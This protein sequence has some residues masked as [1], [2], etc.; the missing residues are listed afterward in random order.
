MALLGLAQDPPSRVA[1]NDPDLVKGIDQVK[2]GDFESAVLNL[3][4]AIQRLGRE[5]SRVKE[6][7]L[8]L[9]YQGV[10][11]VELDQEALAREKFDQAL[12]RDPGFRM[13]PRE[14]SAQQIRI[15]EVVLG[16]R[17]AAASAVPSAKPQGGGSGKILAIVGGGAAVAGIAVAAGGSGSSP[18]TTTTT[19]TTSTL[20]A[21]LCENPPL[22]LWVNP[23]DRETVSG[24]VNLVCSILAG[25]NCP[26][27]SME[28]RRCSGNCGGMPNPQFVTIGPGSFDP[29]NYSIPWVTTTV[30]NG[31]QTLFCFFRVGTISRAPSRV[32]EV[33]N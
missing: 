8:A 13:D 28:F 1:P 19:T 29:P 24:T 5:P 32:V 30:P 26:Q 27:M 25:L 31:P 18:T 2:A 14:F 17:G 22:A 11:Y 7:A 15:F 16:Q 4:A 20:P 23:A 6:L 10:A 33:R 3:Q 9:V 12:R 21:A